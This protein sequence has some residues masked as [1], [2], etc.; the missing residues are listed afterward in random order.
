MSVTPSIS[1]FRKVDIHIMCWCVQT[2]AQTLF[3]LTPADA[4][5]QYNVHKLK[6]DHHSSSLT[7]VALAS[8]M[9]SVTE[10]FKSAES[11][12]SEVHHRNKE[13]MEPHAV[14][15]ALEGQQAAQSL[16]S[17]RGNSYFSWSTRSSGQKRSFLMWRSSPCRLK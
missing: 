9:F 5:L 16:T 13:A 15:N 1:I 8:L 10:V 14:D 4:G 6:Y 17:S 3:V 7:S 12:S 11:E 2:A